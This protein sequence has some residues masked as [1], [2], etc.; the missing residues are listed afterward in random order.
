MAWPATGFFLKALKKTS[1]S[2]AHNNPYI[3]SIAKIFTLVTKNI[4]EKIPV[5]RLGLDIQI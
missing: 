3:L 2:V 4:I 5:A 1:S